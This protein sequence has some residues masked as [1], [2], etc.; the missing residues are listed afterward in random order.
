MTEEE[1]DQVERADVLKLLDEKVLGK[2]QMEYWSVSGNVLKVKIVGSTLSEVNDILRGL[3]ESELVSYST[4][5]TASKEEKT[6]LQS[7]TSV[8]ADIEVYLNGRKAGQEQ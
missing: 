3:N 5:S 2:C 8:T 6:D 1:L 4:V 7:V